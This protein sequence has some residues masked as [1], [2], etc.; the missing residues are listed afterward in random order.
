MKSYGPS[1]TRT[2]PQDRNPTEILLIGGLFAGL[3]P[4]GAVT[5]ASYTVPAGRRFWARAV[6]A[7]A[8]VTIALAAAQLLTIELVI[9]GVGAC[10]RKLLGGSA[11]GSSISMTLGEFHLGAGRVVL[12][13]AVLGAGVGTAE[14]MGCWNGVEY[15]P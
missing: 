7:Y 5:L 2:F 12:L 13:R 1:S 15:D 10:G 14:A 11:V 8:I 6:D 3:P 9:A 4:G